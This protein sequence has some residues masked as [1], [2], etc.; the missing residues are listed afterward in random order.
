MRNIEPVGQS[1]Q[2]RIANPLT[3][4][5]ALQL[6]AGSA[7]D[8]ADGRVIY[9]IEL[10]GPLQDALGNL[11]LDDVRPLLK[12]GVAHAGQ[13]IVRLPGAGELRAIQDSFQL[14]AIGAKAV[15]THWVILT[16]SITVRGAAGTIP[17]SIFR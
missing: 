4:V 5:V 6:L 14:F 3:G 17:R 7:G 13:K 12:S 8:L 11:G 2:D 16:R 9:R 10:I 15:R 1:H